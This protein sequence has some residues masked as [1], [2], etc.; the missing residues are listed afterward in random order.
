MSGFQLRFNVYNSSKVGHANVSFYRDD[1]HVFTIGGNIRLN[2]P[3]LVLPKVFPGEPDDGVM[4][5]ET[6][7]HTQAV[8]EG[9]VLSKPVP[10]TDLEWNSLLDEARALEGQTFNYSPMT[11][12]C[13]EVSEAFYDKSGHPGQF[14]DLFA[15]D[16][17]QG[18]LVWER[19][20]QTRQ[21]LFNPSDDSRPLYEPPVPFMPDPPIPPDPPDLVVFADLPDPA[22]PVDPE[23]DGKVG[24][25]PDI[26][27]NRAVA[28]DEPAQVDA[29]D[30]TAPD[31][32]ETLP[33]DPPADPQRGGRETI[34]GGQNDPV[35]SDEDHGSAPVG[36]AMPNAVAGIG[37]EEIAPPPVA[38]TPPLDSVPFADLPD[39]E[40][41]AAP[42]NPHRTGPETVGA[43]ADLEERGSLEPKDAKDVKAPFINP[44]DT[45]EPLPD[46]PPAERE[47]PSSVEN[48]DAPE[49]SA[50]PDENKQSETGRPPSLTPATEEMREEDGWLPQPPTPLREPIVFAEVPDPP[51]PTAPPWDEILAPA[52][53]DN[54]PDADDIVPNI[55][56]EQAMEEEPEPTPAFDKPTKDGRDKAETPDPEALIEL[57]DQPPAPGS[58]GRSSRETTSSDRRDSPDRDRDTGPDKTDKPARDAPTKAVEREDRQ[59]DTSQRST[60]SQDRDSGGTCDIADD[61]EFDSAAPPPEPAPD[62]DAALP[63]RASLGGDTFGGRNHSYDTVPDYGYDGPSPSSAGSMYDDFF[64]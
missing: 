42:N 37:R 53:A 10:V 27:G 36:P 2:G 25:D 49:Q 35:V 41:P 15:P 7:Y 24:A 47:H 31:R 62:L 63:E 54:G 40:A 34:D 30:I 8:L 60:P 20:A 45:G 19:V 14:G 13:I 12:A 3:Q 32:A 33:D 50:L 44:A 43:D 39:P 57:E 51:Q 28:P 58:P 59:P 52:L 21:P 9:T 5:D 4:Q 55:A 29:S 11:E 1:Q 26:G 6:A 18:A 22:V 23:W 64:L 48:D 17:M 16:E 46:V 38:L 61:F 56:G